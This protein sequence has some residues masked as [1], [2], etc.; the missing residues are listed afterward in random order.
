MKVLVTGGAGY[1]GSHT[2]GLLRARGDQVVVLDTLELGYRQALDDTPIV[3]G[4]T[5]DEDLV[6]KC[7]ASTA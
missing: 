7:C 1:I 6:R 4:N 2:V 3:V 5:R